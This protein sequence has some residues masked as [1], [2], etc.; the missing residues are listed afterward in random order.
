MGRLLLSCSY[1][2]SWDWFY[3]KDYVVLSPVS[4]FKKMLLPEL[5]CPP[6]SEVYVP[7]V[8]AGFG[9]LDEPV[10]LLWALCSEESLALFNALLLLT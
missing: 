10:Q 6:S 1:T 7:V 5:I 4:N 9:A 8:G 2:M 3:P